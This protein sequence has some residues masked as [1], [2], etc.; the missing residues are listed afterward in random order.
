LN[1]IAANDALLTVVFADLASHEG[2]LRGE[3]IE[4]EP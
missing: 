2:I 1:V 3:V 4:A